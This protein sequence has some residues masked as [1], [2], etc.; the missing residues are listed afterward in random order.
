MLYWEPTPG[1]LV[2][3]IYKTVP[4][5]PGPTPEQWKAQRDSRRGGG[6]QANTGGAG[7]RANDPNRVNNGVTGD[8]HLSSKELGKIAVD[9]TIKN[10]VA[11]IEK[12]IAEKRG[13]SER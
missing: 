5:N 13:T 8:P 3:P 6:Q 11:E 10:T 2:R 4:F 9:I 1:A 12:R 7:Q